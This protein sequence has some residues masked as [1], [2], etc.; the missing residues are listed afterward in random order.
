[1]R[2]PSVDLV[3]FKSISLSSPSLSLVL[4]HERI[5]EKP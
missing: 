5:W 4:I 2:A 1:L 3:S